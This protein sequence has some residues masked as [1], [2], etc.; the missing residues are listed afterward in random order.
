MKNHFASNI[1]KRKLSVKVEIVTF[2]SEYKID[3]PW[4]NEKDHIQNTDM[5]SLSELATAVHRCK[6][7]VYPNFSSI[8]VVL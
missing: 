6:L 4:L 3:R 1:V 2:V 5:T 8:V 7:L